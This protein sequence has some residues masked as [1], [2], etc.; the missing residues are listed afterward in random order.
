MS[1]GFHSCL[2]SEELS[3]DVHKNFSLTVE[4]IWNHGYAILDENRYTKFNADFATNSEVSTQD[5][6]SNLLNLNANECDDRGQ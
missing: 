2:D 4:N 5:I 3:V 6:V 1:A